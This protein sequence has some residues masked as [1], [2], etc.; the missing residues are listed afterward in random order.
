M[1][2]TVYDWL[3][4][5]AYFAG[6]AAVGLIGGLR[7][8]GTQTY[9]MGNRR[10]SP[11][12]MIGQSFSVGTHPEMIVAVSGAVYS[13]GA[14]AIWYQWKNLF[15]TPF[16][17]IMAPIFR[18][19]RRTTTAE[20]VEE[21]YGPWMAGIYT[22]FALSFL[23]INT[24]TLLKGAG[25]V[26][27]QALGGTVGVNQVVVGM[28]IVFIFYSFIGGRLATAWNMVI[29][30]ILIVT[31]SFMLIPLGWPLVGGMGGMRS[32]LEPFRFSIVTPEGIGPWVI[33]MLTI[34]GLIGIMAQP[35]IM[36]SVG[37]G[38]DE[39]SCRAG[40]FY[41]NFVKRF[42]T[43]GWTLVGLMTAALVAKEVF[44]TEVLPDPEDAFGFAARHLLFPGLLGLLIAAILAASMAA[45][46]AFMVDSGA[47]F[48]QS[49]YRRYLSKQAADV[50][51]LW[52]G[53]ISGFLIAMAGVLYAVFLIERVLYSFL[54]TETMATYVGISLAGGL[55]WR[56]A[57]RWGALAS[58]LAAFTTNFSLYYLRGERIDHW[59]P[60]VFLASLLAGCVA[61][62]LGSWLTRREDTR[63][64]DS[65]FSR[66][67]TPSDGETEVERGDP[68]R[69]GK[70]LLLLNLLHLRRG[71]GGAGLGQAYRI[72][73]VGLLRGFLLVCA[74]VAAT[75]LLLSLGA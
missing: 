34:N 74:L 41:G 11:W 40:F 7:M 45:C 27:N 70:Q 48:T 55:I 52:V 21:R 57:S 20:F 31:L 49:L 6:V 28:T 35:H 37:S 25:K 5:F 58:L 63:T 36:A 60:D 14:S 67:E 54:L 17:W 72:D 30:G 16:Y 15:A 62:F 8:K 65:L 43:V 71:A 1:Q 2:L 56:R 64:I 24:A 23:T 50:H 10:F 13:T 38:R 51:Y 46:S 29:Q 68:A 22:L 9:F 73:L 42:C 19:V 66:L 53:R 59:D 4:I 75:W 12:V 61:L 18:R 47:L 33:F 26:I 69:E 3:I 39:I 44:G 32:V